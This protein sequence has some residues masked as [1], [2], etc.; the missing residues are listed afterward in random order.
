VSPG[1]LVLLRHGES[2]ANADDLFGGR[3]DYPLTT[4]GRE[5]A[6]EAGRLMRAAGLQP[7]AVHTSLLQRA[8]D[9]AEIAV[10][11]TGSAVGNVRRDWRL[12]ERHYG[13]LQGR[14]R[15][16]VRAELGDEMFD[17]VRRSYD[18]AAPG[19]ESL[20]DVTVRVL[21]Y[22]RA[23]ALPDL[24][25]GQTTLVVAHGN[26]LRA[27]CLHLDALTPAE[28]A[29]LNIPTGVPLR[30]DLDEMLMPLVRGGVYLDAD[31]AAA[32]IAEVA[33]QGRPHRSVR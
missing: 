27:L 5:Q 2:T 21:P 14:S 10:A 6:A 20:A 23:S 4:R 9:T 32:G 7:T 31:R 30:Y 22:W 25:S 33:A 15:V 19:G 13:R 24:R 18:T 17:R 1:V 3:L 12:N 28:V 26:T 29:G 16:A 11:H 8:V